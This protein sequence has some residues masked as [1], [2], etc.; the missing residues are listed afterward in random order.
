MFPI[1]Y[2]KFNTMSKFYFIVAEILSKQVDL[3]FTL[4]THIQ[5]QEISTPILKTQEVGLFCFFF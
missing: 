4:E 3:R 2:R 5:G 1:R